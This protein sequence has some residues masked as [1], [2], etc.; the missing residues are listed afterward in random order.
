[1]KNATVK[2]KRHRWVCPTCAKVHIDFKKDECRNE[3]CPDYFQRKPKD[4][5]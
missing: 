5:G 3:R 2:R 1:M 4:S